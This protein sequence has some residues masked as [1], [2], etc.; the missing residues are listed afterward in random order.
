MFRY[1]ERIGDVQSLALL[2]C[3]LSEPFGNTSY[4]EEMD[5][6]TPD[7]TQPPPAQPPS[8]LPST[9]Q[10]TQSYFPHRRP[11]KRASTPNQGLFLSG[12]LDLLL[13]TNDSS[14]LPVKSVSN[15][16]HAIARTYSG[17]KLVGMSAAVASNNNG[18][19][20]TTSATTTATTTTGS[21]ARPIKNPG[22]TNNHNVSSLGSQP[23]IGSYMSENESGHPVFG[24]APPPQDDAG[25]DGGGDIVLGGGS[26]G[27]GGGVHVVRRHQQGKRDSGSP[28]DSG[29]GGVGA[30]AGRKWMKSPMPQRLLSG[31]S[32][33]AAAAG[34]G[35]MVGGGGGGVLDVRDFNTSA[36]H[37]GRKSMKMGLFPER[38]ESGGREGGGGG[39]GGVKAGGRIPNE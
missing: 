26:G 34:G 33:S 19:A 36:E 8:S 3:V 13:T 18:G 1:L 7:S 37:S 2:S 6:V 25:Q 38:M 30:A 20:T 5:P 14:S 28:F 16:H 39:G 4:F 32:G 15:R 35:G 22:K 12:P 10:S 23:V 17:G 9:Y 21:T 27:G 24:A 29:S 31:G 11:T